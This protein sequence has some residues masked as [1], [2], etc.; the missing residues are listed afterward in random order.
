MKIA[1][2]GFTLIEIM[3]V[4]VLMAIAGVLA[5]PEVRRMY[6][7]ARM[8]A[9]AREVATFLKLAKNRALSE[10]VAMGVLIEPGARSLRLL[11]ENGTEVQKLVLAEDIEIPRVVIDRQPDETEG[12][13]P[14]DEDQAEQERMPLVWF[15]PDGRC[16]GVALVLKQKAGREFRLKTD[17]L[18]GV[19]RIYKTSDEGFNDEV[20]K[21]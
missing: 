14:E 12:A 8:D 19:T 11:K 1:R 7:Q 21:P 13:Q 6:D 20:F 18:T 9:S 4:L 16:S 3:V 15:Y 17:I 2:S 5:F 10:Q